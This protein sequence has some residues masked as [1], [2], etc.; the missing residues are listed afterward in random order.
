MKMVVVEN[1]Y[2]L[3]LVFGEEMGLII[4]VLKEGSVMIRYYLK[5]KILDLRIFMLKMEE[6]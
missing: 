5:N 1:V 6:F 3:V 2:V 4:V